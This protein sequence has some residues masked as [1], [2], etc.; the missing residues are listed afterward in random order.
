MGIRIADVDRDILH[1]ETTKFGELVAVNCGER[2]QAFA[3][4]DEAVT[5][6]TN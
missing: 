4:L 5:W 2:E 1:L 6:L 3:S